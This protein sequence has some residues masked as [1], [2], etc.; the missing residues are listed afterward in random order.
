MAARRYGGQYVEL[1]YMVL[2]A[3]DKMAVA[4]IDLR[5]CGSTS[6][7]FCLSTLLCTT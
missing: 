4:G 6:T 1:T 7:N 5:F 2:R 3:G